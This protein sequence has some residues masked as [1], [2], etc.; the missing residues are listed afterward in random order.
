DEL[1][2]A[3]AIGLGRFPGEVEAAR[4]L[5]DRADAVLPIVARDEIAA[6]IAHDGEPELAQVRQLVLAERAL[7][8]LRMPELNDSA[9]VAGAH[10][11]DEGDKQMP[12]GGT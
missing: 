1:V 11:V 4:P 8:C 3:E 2:G 10:V 7:V 12:S 5:F 9:R 6:G